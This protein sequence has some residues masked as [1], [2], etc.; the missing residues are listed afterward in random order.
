VQGVG[1]GKC[2][3]TPIMSKVPQVIFQ[4]LSATSMKLA[5]ALMMEVISIS[6]TS[7]NL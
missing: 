7:V 3:I 2:C 6:D 1:G 5:T 4:V